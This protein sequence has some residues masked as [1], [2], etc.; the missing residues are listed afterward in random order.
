MSLGATDQLRSLF[1]KGFKL[2]KQGNYE[3]PTYLGFKV[4]FD[5]GTLPVNNDDGMPPSPLLKHDNYVANPNSNPFG[6][7]QYEGRSNPT[8]QFYSAS[9]FLKDR[10]TGITIS[11]G[12][13]K[14]S[15]MIDAFVRNLK[16]LTDQYPWFIQ[17]IT[18]LDKLS[19]HPRGGYQDQGTFVFNPQ[20]TKDKTIEFKTLESLNLRM[21]ALATLYNQATFDYDNMRELLPRNLR[22]FTMY[23]FVSEIRNFFKTSRLIGSSTTLKA[24]DDLSSLLSPGNNPGNDVAYSYNENQSYPNVPSNIDPASSFNAFI[25][26]IGN[27]AGLDND[28]SMFQN[29]QDQSG[30][31]PVIVFE[32]KNCEFDFSE[33]TPLT[34]ET[35]Q[36]SGQATPNTMSF[37]IHIGKLRMK[38]QFPNI[39]KDGKPLILADSW[40]GIR[41][42]VE[43]TQ[44]P[45]VLDDILSTGGELLT[46]FIS[47]SLN[48]MVN[49]GVAN[50]ASNLKGSDQL[51]L[52]NA[53]SF[54]TSQ[55]AA[56]LSFNSAQNFFN[57]L[58]KASTSGLPNPQTMGQGGPPQNVYPGP[59]KQ[60]QYP[61]NPGS[62]LGVPGR[63]Y[64]T[65][66]ADVYSDVPGKDLGVPG[67]VYTAP[68]GDEYP[69]NP[70]PDLGV[71]GRTYIGPNGDEYPDVP[72]KDLGVPQRVYISPTGDEYPTNPGPDLGVPNR[73]YIA[74][75]GDEYPTNPGPDLGVPNRV[76]IAPTGD[77]YPTNPGPDLG[78][79]NRSYIAPTGDEYP[80]NPG[81]DLGV[82]QRAYIAPAG[83]EYPTNPGKDL[84]VPQRAYIAP[85][86]DEYPNVPGSD[87]G[88]AARAYS[89]PAGDVYPNVPGSDLGIP[90]RDYASPASTIYPQPTKVFANG[91][92]RD[93]SN[94]FTSQ[95][96]TVYSQQI[97]QRS[98]GE[99]G[100]AYPQTSGDFIIDQPLNLGNVKP[101][102]KYNISMDAFNTPQS[103]FE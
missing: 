42:S 36:G 54:N 8:V 44:S 1:L 60:D 48:D 6:S 34:S 95:P 97:P 30:I 91:E 14:R 51:I 76:Y 52:G 45:G 17:S 13:G 38:S 50:F 12:D 89:G 83:D 102:D 65:V 4:I 93:S 64:P 70:G 56:G 10:E 49:E 78:V 3:D 19:Q 20:R 35:T 68:T 72:G 58:G 84:G 46:N 57:S 94:T 77:E 22:R 92:S 71:P 86:G 53:Y 63:V 88:V 24:I 18:G 101:P 74:P 82:P 69:T 41:S 100:K 96:G 25:G 26:N 87:L 59:G 85:A 16:E 43:K 90:Q 81:K 47:N 5:F 73:V 32:C 62:D 33:S 21:T 7:A 103:E 9:G 66:N 39:R 29:Q 31:K 28:L 80:T 2:S 61:T 99:I 79:P 55:L 27:N 23:I 15:D 40:D 67:R 37:K 98:R 75:T 11:G